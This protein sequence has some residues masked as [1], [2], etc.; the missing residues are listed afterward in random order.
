[1]DKRTGASNGKG[2]TYK[3]IIHTGA[4]KAKGTCCHSI[5]K[6]DSGV[7]KTCERENPRK[8]ECLNYP[9]GDEL[10]LKAQGASH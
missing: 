2:H 1:M 3:T 4:N 8:N 10:I 6:I 9:V 5:G 7:S